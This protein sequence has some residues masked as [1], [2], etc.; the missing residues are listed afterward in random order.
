MTVA[1]TINRWEYTGNAITVDFQYANR[2][3][4]STD[5]LVYLDGVLQAAGYTVSGVDAPGGGNVT[6]AVAPGVG[7]VV[8]I[9]RAVPDAQPLKF[10]ND[11]AVD[12]VLFAEGLDRATIQIQQASA[13]IARSLRLPIEEIV[14]P[15][16]TLPALALR[17]SNPLGFDSLGA[18]IA[19]AAPAG[20]TTLSTFGAV[21][22]VAADD[23]AARILL[24]AATHGYRPAPRDP[25]TM[26]VAIGAG[27]FFNAVTRARVENA[28]QLTAAFVAPITDPRN[29]FIY[30]DRLTG[31]VGVAAGSEAPVPVD[32]ALPA[33]KVLN[34]R[35][36]LTTGMIAIA[37]T[38]IDDLRDMD[39][40]GT[41]DL[42]EASKA[43]IQRQAFSA[44]DDTGAAD[45][46]VITPVPAIAAYAKY[47]TWIVDI[48]N[49]NTGASTIA[50]SGQAARDIF[51]FRTGA[52]LTGGEIVAGLNVFVDDGTRVNLITTAKL[53]RLWAFRDV[54][55]STGDGGGSTASTWN[56]RKF[57]AA[58]EIREIPGAGPINDINYISQTANFTVGQIVTGGTT[59]D[60]GLIVAD[61]DAG[62]TGTLS[63][64]N[65]DGPFVNGELLTDPLGGS[66]TA[67]SPVLLTT[68]TQFFLPA[69]TYDIAASAP[70]YAAGT[71]QAR[72][73]DV[74]NGV[75]LVVGTSQSANASNLVGNRSHVN[76]RFTLSGD[77][78]LELQHWTET[79]RA[80]D[81]LGLASDS[82]E[83]EVYSEIQL[84]RVV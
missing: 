6:F 31:I 25:A 24:D 71:H 72:L 77:A 9:V 17:A 10:I 13:E 18:P 69:G 67:S 56:V 49:A 42:V 4:A 80:A 60:T 41:A 66:A 3:F 81:G 64:I 53:S 37:A 47:Q 50:I 83:S 82:G 14:G 22:V 39:L 62:A 20:T 38:D 30:V 29:D 43:E 19:L 70:A 33:G 11:V 5:L 58:S 61:A 35:V 1:T 34:S 8:V 73:R 57:A 16:M 48:A 23:A 7:V 75:T 68:F 78:V 54:V 44:F 76:G 40:L 15:D 27:A 2:I 32:P 63:L 74:T 28:G 65:Q 55:I 84:R 51:D 79:T 59:G 36:R 26:I 21:L 12:A 46:Y 52:A 45:A